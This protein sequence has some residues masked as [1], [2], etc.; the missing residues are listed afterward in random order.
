MLGKGLDLPKLSLVGIVNADTGLAMPDFSSTER[1][2][3]LL[4]QAIGRVGRGHVGG[5]VILQSFNPDSSLLGAAVAQDWQ[6]FY[7]QELDERKS[8][9]FPPY[10]FLLKISVSRKTSD[11]AEQYANKLRHAIAELKLPVSIN[12]AAPAF[13]ER[14]HGLY[15]WQVVIKAKDR[16]HLVSIVQSLPKGDYVADL[17][18]TN[19]L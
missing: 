5:E 4:H 3:Q 15:N 11:V 14:S 10:C 6:R 19:L 8:F 18:P 13:Y 12:E 17:D 1:S 2:Y 16:K 9:V 7:K